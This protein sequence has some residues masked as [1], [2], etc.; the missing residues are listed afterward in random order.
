[1]TY[2]NVFLNDFEIVISGLLTAGSNCCFCDP[3]IQLHFVLCYLFTVKYVAHNLKN[4]DDDSNDKAIWK[5]Y[6]VSTESTRCY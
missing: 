3:F 5:K 2:G 4:D 6:E 1:M